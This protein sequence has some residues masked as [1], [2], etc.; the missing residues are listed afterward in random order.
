MDLG[1]R[2][3]NVQSVLTEHTVQMR[4]CDLYLIV[5]ES[6]FRLDIHGDSFSLSPG[7]ESHDCLQALRQLVGDT[8][9]DATADA[10][11]ALHVIFEGGAHLT[12]EPDPD[13]EGW[14]VSGPGGA[15]VVS[16]PGGELAIWTAQSNADE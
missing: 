7:M 12:V 13:Y 1:L 2:G 14:S 6:P 3:K 16:T 10:A 11:G 15:L 4:L 9:E 5:I 8:I